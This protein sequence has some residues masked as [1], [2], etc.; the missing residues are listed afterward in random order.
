MQ[1]TH[2]Y[3]IGDLARL[4]G[5]TV[6]TLRYYEELGLLEPG[7]R[8]ESEHRRYP[9]KNIIYLR[10]IQQLKDYG[11]SLGE[12][13]ELFR[14]SREDRSGER[15]RRELAVKYREKLMEAQKRKES[16][17]LYMAD[18]AWHIEQLENVDDFFQCPGASC[19]A[20][21]FLD[22]CD[23]KLEPPAAKKGM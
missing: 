5:V 2:E 9:E 22:R 6:R 8:S 23:M 12:I 1:T 21:A 18:L 17:D 13:G 14:L 11:L 16:L 10:R 19:P 20:C 15:V 3:R 7:E 4:F